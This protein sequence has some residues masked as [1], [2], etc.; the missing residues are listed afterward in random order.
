MPCGAPSSRRTPVAS[1]P[2]IFTSG[3][4]TT[5]TVP[6]YRTAFF[7]R[8]IGIIA[9]STRSRGR[10]VSSVSATVSWS[11]S[12]NRTSIVSSEAPRTSR[13][14]FTF[15]PSSARTVWPGARSRSTPSTGARR[16]V[17]ESAVRSPVRASPISATVSNAAPRSAS[18]RR[19][20]ASG[21]IQSWKSPVSSG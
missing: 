14:V 5:P 18:I 13:H 3:L 12:V 10:S 16:T 17:T 7:T 6:R 21:F 9:V 15:F 20:G 2:S 19:A 8:T 11:G 1:I 4:A